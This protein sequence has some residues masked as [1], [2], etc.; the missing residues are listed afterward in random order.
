MSVQDSDERAA[1][2]ERLNSFGP[3]QVTMRVFD[4]KSD[5]EIRKRTFNYNDIEL[6]SWYGKTVIW[7]LKHGYAIE[8]EPA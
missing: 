5:E 8:L 7:A 1:V 3:L 4:V 6:R 2:Q